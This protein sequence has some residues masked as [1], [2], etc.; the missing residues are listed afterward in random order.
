MKQSELKALGTRL[1]DFVRHF[2]GE[3]GRAERLR[4]CEQYLSG[5]LLD[6]ERKSVEPMAARLEGADV[7]AL[8]Q[9]VSQSPWDHEAVQLS[10]TRLMLERQRAGRRAP[11]QNAEANSARGRGVEDGRQEPRH[12]LHEVDA[13]AVLCDTT[14]PKRGRHS[15][16]VHAG[17][18]GGAKSAGRQTV[19]TWHYLDPRGHFPLAC[20]LFLPEVWAG[21][22][23]RMERAGVPAGRRRFR[24]RWEVALELLG[25]W[26]RA[27]EAVNESGMKISVKAVV[28]DVEYGGSREFRRALDARGYV[29]V[30]PVGEGEI[31]WPAGDSTS[32]RPGEASVWDGP[33]AAGPLP[34]CEWAAEA[35]RR[36]G[37]WQSAKGPLGGRGDSEILAARVRES[38]GNGRGSDER[39]LVVERAGG[40]ETRY[41]LSNASRD[42]K[43]SQL[44]SWARERLRV[45]RGRRQMEEELGLGH[46]E[47]RSWR[48]LHHHLTLCFMAYCFLRLEQYKVKGKRKLYA[49]AAVRAM[50]HDEAERRAAALAPPPAETPGGESL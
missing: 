6:G 5:L 50:Q 30:T 9:F 7:Q 11:A 10:L 17:R 1:G 12:F 23:A 16:G 33:E 22:E 20:E 3:L 37:K 35:L 49:E 24:E 36:G 19:V 41:Y 38:A 27:L 28:C 2:A 45:E 15:V 18:D 31:Y 34:A 4:W 14:L 29:F 13:V 25:R 46:F 8:Q 39:W 44:M 32:A 40:G 48:G 21:D 43:P 47:G 42:E 26:G